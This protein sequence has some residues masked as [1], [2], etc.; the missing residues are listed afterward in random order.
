[1]FQPSNPPFFQKSSQ[2][3][4]R[5]IN[6]SSTTATEL[7]W[8]PAPCGI[9]IMGKR[10]G[11]K[12]EHKQ[13]W[14]RTAL[15]AA[16]WYSAPK[17][18]P[19][20]LFVASD[21]HGPLLTPDAQVVKSMLVD[22]F[23]IPSD[24]VMTRQLTNCTLLEVRAAR[25]LKKTYGLAHIFALTHLYHAARAQRYFNEVMPTASVIPV[26]PDILSEITFPVEAEELFNELRTL[27]EASLPGRWDG[28]RE[29]VIEWL[30]NQAHTLD[31]RGRFE[32]WLARRLRPEAYT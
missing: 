12:R 9:L 10:Q 29:A 8:P 24:F 15:A 5:I 23:G 2:M 1:M 31:P 16:L 28:A 20:L 7:N 4:S 32:R 26:H 17:P 18:K 6:P 30:L 25:M 14:G 3:S 21:L 22:R 19:Y 13:L 27:I 11:T